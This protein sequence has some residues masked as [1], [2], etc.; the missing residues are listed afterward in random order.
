[1]CSK[2]FHFSL[3]FHSNLTDQNEA[4]VPEKGPEVFLVKTVAEAPP[5]GN[6]EKS[7][8]FLNRPMK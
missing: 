4:K 8:S 5:T 2:L 6:S 7:S 1:M 3:D